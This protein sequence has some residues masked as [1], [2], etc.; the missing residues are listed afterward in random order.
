MLTCIIR[1]ALSWL[2]TGS[3]HVQGGPYNTPVD[4][5]YKVSGRPSCLEIGRS[6]E[7]QILWCWNRR[8]NR[9]DFI[10]I[11]AVCVTVCTRDSQRFRCGR[12]F[13]QVI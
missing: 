10:G 2:G 4:G 6:L 5:L 8:F 9:F 3:G 13:N 1:N 12:K 7:Q 11:G